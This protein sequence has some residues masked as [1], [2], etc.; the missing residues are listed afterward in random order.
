MLLEIETLGPYPR[1]TEI[2]I[3]IL[4]ICPGFL[5]EFEKHWCKEQI[6]KT[7]AAI[8]P[9]QRISCFPFAFIAPLEI[10]R[11]YVWGRRMKEMEKCY[12]RSRNGWESE[13]LGAQ[14][15]LEILEW[16]RHIST[17]LL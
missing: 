12:D 4:T 3:C 2:R 13:D 8:D 5:L 17:I 11:Q 15:D 14:R 10:K 16:V 6:C 9:R 1:L 7:D